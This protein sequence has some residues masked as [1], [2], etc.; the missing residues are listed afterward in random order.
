A[1]LLAVVGGVALVP[2]VVLP[3]LAVPVLLAP[4]RRVR[5]AM[6]MVADKGAFRVLLDDDGV[7]VGNEV[8]VAEF[9]WPDQRYHLETPGLFLLLGGDEE[10]RV[11][12]MV[13]KRGTEDVG[14]LRELIERH[15]VA[16]VPD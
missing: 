6:R 10:T 14:Q 4:R 2:A 12:T 8:S 5:Q 13:P 1:G 7:V 15:S 11:L 9:G 3:V 16:L